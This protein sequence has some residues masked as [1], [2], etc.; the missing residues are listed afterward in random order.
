MVSQAP[1]DVRARK[2]KETINKTI[3]AI[4]KSNP[5][6]RK[7]IEAVELISDLPP[8]SLFGPDDTGPKTTTARGNI[9]EPSQEQQPPQIQLRVIDTLEAASQLAARS[10]SVPADRRH[11]S[12]RVGILNMASPLRPGGGVLTGATS[13]EEWLCTRTT[14]YP[15]LRDAFYRLPEVGGVY[16]PDVLVFRRG[17]RDATELPKAERFFVDVVS[18]AMLRFP[19]LADAVAAADAP[20][21]AAAGRRQQQQQREQGVF[22]GGGVVYAEDRDRETVGRKMRAV[23]RMFR[24]RG[25][26][27]IVLG[28]WGCGAYGN[29]VGEVARAWKRV[30]LGGGSGRAKHNKNKAGEMWDG[31]EVVFAIKNKGMAEQFARHFGPG[32]DVVEDGSGS[33]GSEEDGESTGDLEADI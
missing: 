32:L 6:A 27:R 18:A 22:D 4:L 31:L 2:A 20:D 15:S 9:Q 10:S 28:A 1:K 11:V 14:L 12:P 7:G 33:D 5:R 25:V 29:P 19:D 21:A 16:T 13:Q 8:L 17:D 23:L 24:A 3:P 26:D 30:L